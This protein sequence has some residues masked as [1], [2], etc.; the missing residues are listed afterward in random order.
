MIDDQTSDGEEDDEDL[1]EEDT[2]LLTRDT[3]ENQMSSEDTTAGRESMPVTDETIL[4]ESV[5]VVK[6]PPTPQREPSPTVTP[7]TVPAPAPTA[8]AAPFEPP[9]MTVPDLTATGQS[10]ASLVA[11]DAV[12]EGKLVCTGNVRIEGKLR[13]EVETDGTLFV[14]AE[15]QVD[16]TVRAR[17]VTL[18]GEIKGDL[19]CAERLEI[20]PGGA[21]RGDV[22]T[23]ALIVHEGA[24]I[25]SRFQMQREVAAR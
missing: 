3:Q 8:F 16:G 15:A 2:V 4:E 14:S 18:A 17:N 24:F 1:M 19:H 12:W 21:A 7:A 13:G 6:A 9:R 5:T 23:G 22:Q 25:D 11:K 10:G 20:L